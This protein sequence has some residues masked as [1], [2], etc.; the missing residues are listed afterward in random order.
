MSA[1]ARWLI[2]RSSSTPAIIGGIG[3]EAANIAHRQSETIEPGIDV[4]RRGKFL[5]ARPAERR[6]GHDVI[7]RREN[8]LHREARKRRGDVSDQS[9]ERVD[10]GCGANLRAISAS[11]GVAMKNVVQPART[12][13]GDHALGT[14]AIGVGLDDGTAAR[15]ARPS[16]PVPSSW[17]RSA[18]RS[19]VIVPVALARLSGMRAF[20]VISL[21]PYVDPGHRPGSI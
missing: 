19:I 21:F 5:A 16:P 20:T 15:P 13:A 8:G 17:R 14:K 12:S 1:E 6:P 10:F 3:G 4:Q 2:T 9:I 11:S 18:P 7:E